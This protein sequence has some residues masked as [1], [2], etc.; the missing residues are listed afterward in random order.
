MYHLFK[1]LNFLM[2]V[3]NFKIQYYQVWS[4]ELI[5]NEPDSKIHPVNNDHGKFVKAPTVTDIVTRIGI[6]IYDF[7]DEMND[8]GE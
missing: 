2:W 1:N 4:F 7:M 3:F 5:T 8:A 6:H